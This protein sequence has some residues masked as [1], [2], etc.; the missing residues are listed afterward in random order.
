MFGEDV[1]IESSLESDS[2]GYDSGSDYF[3]ISD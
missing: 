3:W 2:I 1:I